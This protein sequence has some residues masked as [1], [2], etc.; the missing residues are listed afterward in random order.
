MLMSRRQVALACACLTM[1]FVGSAFA[2][3]KPYQGE[4]VMTQSG[5]LKPPWKKYRWCKTDASCSTLIRNPVTHEV[6]RLGDRWSSRFEPTGR[7]QEVRRVESAMAKAIRLSD[8]KNASPS[9]TP[10]K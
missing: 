1:T 6:A 7:G 2:Q 4:I 10:P 9:N 5:D 3:V 8:A